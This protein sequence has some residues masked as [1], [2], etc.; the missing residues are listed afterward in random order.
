MATV[1]DDITAKM[2]ELAQDFAGT[3]TPNAIMAEYTSWRIGGP[4]DWL[5]EPAS[6]AEVIRVMNFC[7]TN[8]LELTIIGRGT[9]LL[10]S[11]KG[12]AG[13]VLKIGENLSKVEIE[14]QPEAYLLHAECG[15][16]LAALSRQ[17]AEAGIGG[18]EWAC[19]I[20]GNLGGALMMNAGAYGS[21]IGEF[22]TEVQAVAYTGA[23]KQ[24]AVL[25][26]LRGEALHFGYR[27]GC[28]PKDTVA[29]GVTLRLP[30]GNETTREALLAHIGDILSSRR[31]NQP[32]EYPSAG[33]VF[34]NPE[35]SHA[36]YL[37]E[38]A[39]CKGLTVGDAQVSQK[40]G[41]FIINLGGAKAAD[42]LSLIEQ[43]RSIVAEKTGYN[44]ETE[45]RLLGR[46][47]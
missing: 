23:E 44:L 10:V 11:D 32:L 5:V 35:G 28:L 12:I 18:L 3:I 36:G 38:Q 25:Q 2:H 27:S 42:V 16:L 41:N 4:A 8:Q 34:R 39:G 43:V 45:V 31:Q 37:I 6:A 47:N 15:V 29:L 33:S 20:P 13:V 21:S 9:N 30:I 7:R 14:R 46:A 1:N 24:E 40:H 17:T 26:T 22:V 19:G